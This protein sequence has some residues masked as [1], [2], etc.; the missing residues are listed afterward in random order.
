MIS[1]A[2]ACAMDSSRRVQNESR[3]EPCI[4]RLPPAPLIT[5]KVDGL[6]LLVPGA[7][8]FGVFVIPV[9]S[10]RSVRRSSS[11]IGKV[12]NSDTFSDLA[13]GARSSPK[14]GLGRDDKLRCK[15]TECSYVEIGI[16]DTA[17]CVALVTKP[18]VR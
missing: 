16:Q 3:S 6:D 14:R 13:P 11:V 12:L 9:A 7:S 4:C 10:R 18:L 1:G 8:K 15:R 17:R 2:T 5:P